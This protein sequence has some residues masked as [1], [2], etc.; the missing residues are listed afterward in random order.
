MKRIPCVIFIISPLPKEI[1]SV[2]RYRLMIFEGVCPRS[3]WSTTQIL[4]KVELGGPRDNSCRKS[5]YNDDHIW[6]IK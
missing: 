5:S 6:N 3:T 1:L 2:L 4:N